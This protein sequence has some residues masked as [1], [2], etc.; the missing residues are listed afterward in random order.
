MKKLTKAQ[1]S[2]RRQMHK[3]VLRLAAAE[4]E[5]GRAKLAYSRAF[6]RVVTSWPR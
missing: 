4:R 2:I 3:S 1:K 6:T 5:L